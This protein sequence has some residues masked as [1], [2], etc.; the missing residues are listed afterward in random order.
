MI[1]ESSCICL[2]SGFE[3]NIYIML[4]NSSYVSNVADSI[5]TERYMGLPTSEDNIE[6]YQ[7]AQLLDKYEGIR[8]KQYF[9]VHGTLDDNVHYQQS[10]LWA[11]VLEHRDILFDQLVRITTSKL[12]HKW[13][14]WRMELI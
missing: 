14:C 11:K 7:N 5:Y 10:M 13:E 6:G 9:L 2:F 8:D 3:L 1:K 4:T 12:S